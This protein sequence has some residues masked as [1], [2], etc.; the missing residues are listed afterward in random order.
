MAHIHNVV[1]S[2]KYFVIDPITRRITNTSGKISL[3]QLDH[4]SERFT[5]EI[6]RLIDNHDMSLCNKVEVHYI[7]TDGI[8]SNDGIYEVDDL[9][10]SAGSEDKVTFSWLISQNVTQYVGDVNFAI[11]YACTTDDVIDYQWHTDICSGIT[12][13]ETLNNSNNIVTEYTDILEQWRKKLF[14]AGDSTTGADWDA[15]EGE[16]GYV[17]NRTH[18]SEYEKKTL[19]EETV[20]TALEETENAAPIPKILDMTYVSEVEVTYNGTTY[21]CPITTFEGNTYG[22]GNL[23]AVDEDSEGGNGEPFVV[24]IYA[25]KT[26][27][28]DCNGFVLPLDGSNEF[29]MSIV[30]VVETVYPLD[31][32]Y[33]PSTQYV[34]NFT[35]NTSSS[36]DSDRSFYEIASVLTE[37]KFNVVGVVVDGDQRVYLDVQYWDLE[38]VKFGREIVDESTGVL[39]DEIVIYSTDMVQ[40]NSRRYNVNNTPNS[41]WTTEQITLLENL[42]SR[43]TAD[44]SE[45]A[46]IATQLIASL[47]GTTPASET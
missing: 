10:V 42:L 5:F 9:S 25:N 40:Y 39:Q 37:G 46:T 23:S 41:G 44:D 8:F 22:F 33:L 15:A 12:V 35:L 19:L 27:A 16:P 24:I 26:I 4:N 34:V 14:G 29:T 30:G 6:P 18:Y 17:L 45:S 2:D 1:D 21:I 38:S 3:M 28:D 20:L 47:R 7:N 36:F 13:G 31:E 43:I 32:K 11:L